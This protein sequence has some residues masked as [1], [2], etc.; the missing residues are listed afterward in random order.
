MKKHL[1]IIIGFLNCNG[2]FIKVW[3][4]YRTFDTH[5]RY[6]CRACILTEIFLRVLYYRQLRHNTYAHEVCQCGAI[7]LHIVQWRL[8][9]E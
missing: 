6:F 8:F 5:R 3:F 1:E 2:V 9:I 7:L 4:T